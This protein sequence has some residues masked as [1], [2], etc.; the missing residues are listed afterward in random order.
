[1]NTDKILCEGDCDK[2]ESYKDGKCI[3]GYENVFPSWF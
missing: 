1:M 2:C 3:H